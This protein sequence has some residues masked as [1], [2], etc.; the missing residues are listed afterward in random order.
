MKINIVLKMTHTTLQ[1]LVTNAMFK[2]FEDVPHCF[3]KVITFYIPTSNVWE[4]S[5]FST[6]YLTQLSAPFIAILSRCGV[7]SGGSDLNL[8]NNDFEQCA[9]CHV[10]GFFRVM[11]TQN[12]CSLFHWFSFCCSALRILDVNPLLWFINTFSYLWM[13]TVVWIWNVPQKSHVW[14]LVSNAVMIKEKALGKWLDH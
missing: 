6:S 1:E 10:D 11:R 2:H 5:N 4:S 8:L 9:H 13:I 14:G 3:F 7:V 12:F